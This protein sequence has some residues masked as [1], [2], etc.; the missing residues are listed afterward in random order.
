LQIDLKQL[1]VRWTTAKFGLQRILAAIDGF[2]RILDRCQN[3]LVLAC[4][5]QA[6]QQCRECL[7]GLEDC[8]ALVLLRH[9]TLVA[10]RLGEWCF[11]NEA[12]YCNRRTMSFT[13]AR[14]I[15]RKGAHIQIS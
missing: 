10:S 11:I 2:D 8:L 4:D 12:R 9:I 15:I 3:D 13:V 1:G 7:R 6:L 5:V 14:S